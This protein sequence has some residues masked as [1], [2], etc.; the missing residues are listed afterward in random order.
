M[1][2]MATSV[3]VVADEPELLATY[4]PEGAMFAFADGHPL[5]PHPWSGRAAWQGHGVL[6]LQRPGESYA[7]WHFWG[8]D[9]RAFEG[10]YVNIQEPFRR[11]AAGDDTQ[12]LELDVWAP[13]EGG[14]SL[15]DDDL[16]DV[17]V[18]SGRFTPAEAAAIREIGAGVGALIDAG[19]GWWD[20]AWSGWE[21]DPAWRPLAPP[22]GWE[23]S[24]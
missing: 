13:A 10:W 22:P 4:L 24:A 19:A 3:I 16:V 12:D 2:W 7:V 20:P 9:A 21:P 15:K 8:G 14:G 11:T 18:A 1:P 6:M 5:G 23:S 17:H